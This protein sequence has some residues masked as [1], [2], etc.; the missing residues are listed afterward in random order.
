MP[1]ELTVAT[2]ERALTEAPGV[3]E[4]VVDLTYEY[5]PVQVDFAGLRAIAQLRGMDL[6]RLVFDQVVG[7]RALGRFQMLLLRKLPHLATDL[8]IEDITRF[9]DATMAPGGDALPLEIFNAFLRRSGGFHCLISR[10]GVTVGSGALVSPR[11]VLTAAHVVEAMVDGP[12]DA[13]DL[14]AI[15]AREYFV[16]PG[17]GVPYPAQVV[18]VS[19]CLRIEANGDIPAPQHA[20]SF[21]DV[22]LLK[23][24]DPIGREYGHITLG[25]PTEPE[26]LTEL[27]VMPHYPN[28]A[29]AGLAHGDLARA[30]DDIRSKHSIQTAPGSSGAPGFCRNTHFIGLHQGAWEDVRRLVPYTQFHDNPEF[31]AMIAGDVPPRELWSLTDKIDGHVIIGRGQYFQMFNAVA[32]GTHPSLRGS[33]IQRDAFD[34]REGLGFSYDIAVKYLD[35][36]GLPHSIHRV[37]ID[38]DTEDLFEKVHE[39]VFVQ[40]AAPEANDGVREDETTEA[41]NDED[42]SKALAL[43]LAQLARSRGASVWLF[44]EDPQRDMKDSIRQQLQHFVAMLLQEEGVYL[45]LSG[46]D[47]LE[48][49]VPTVSDLDAL[50]P[51]RPALLVE[52]LRRFTHSDV[53]TVLRAAAAD[54]RL[55]WDRERAESEAR[56]LL[57]PFPLEAGAYNA[58]YLREAAKRIQELLKL[59]V[60]WQREVA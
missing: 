2:L 16:Q 22:A 35:I 24:T 27:I 17:D 15:N 32:E 5:E 20:K 50:D 14:D 47:T 8:R 23:T 3:V 36:L 48:S 37:Q 53:E 12:A 40:G 56:D 41:A 9:R 54:L 6:A 1:F 25:N 10:A 39:N 46:F 59:K 45:I 31:Q 52:T 43:R 18:W 4:T 42:R 30:P 7:D 28:G 55:G 51:D 58:R 29:F 60:R 21:A 33:W 44:F 34:Q 13:L 11:L 57:Q 38:G 19:A 26:G 49:A